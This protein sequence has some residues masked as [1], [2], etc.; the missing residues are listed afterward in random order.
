MRRP[1][2]SSRAGTW[3]SGRRIFEDD[4]QEGLCSVSGLGCLQKFRS[5]QSIYEPMLLDV[6]T[7]SRQLLDHV[8]LKQSAELQDLRSRPFHGEVWEEAQELIPDHFMLYGRPTLEW[9]DS[10]PCDLIFFHRSMWA[11]IDNLFVHR[12]SKV[13]SRHSIW[14]SLE[15]RHMS[16]MLFCSFTPKAILTMRPVAWGLSR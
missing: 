7:S 13:F 6:C 1:L 8:L 3:S 9:I 12:C 14:N 15:W 4:S 11:W 16:S 5:V 10:S 2:W